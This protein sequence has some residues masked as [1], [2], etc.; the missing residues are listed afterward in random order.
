MAIFEAALSKINAVDTASGKRKKQGDIIT[1]RPQGWSWTD[2]EKLH[3]TIALIQSN[4][5]TADD[6]RVRV[7]NWRNPVNEKNRFKIQFNDIKVLFPAWDKDQASDEESS[8]QWLLDNAQVID[9]DNDT[10]VFDI[11]LDDYINLN[12][13]AVRPAEE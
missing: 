8:Y 7:K 6:I 13:I 2:R 5:L 1:V 3:Y 10:A 4:T 9:I 11:E 12:S